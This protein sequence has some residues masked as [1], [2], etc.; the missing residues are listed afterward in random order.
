MD[1]F[2]IDEVMNLVYLFVLSMCHACGQCLCYVYTVWIPIVYNVVRIPNF[3][4]I[5]IQTNP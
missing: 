3:H 5:F 2:V 4:V 1:E